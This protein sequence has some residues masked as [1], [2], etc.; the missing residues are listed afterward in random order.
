MDDLPILTPGKPARSAEMIAMHQR[1]A[2][3][4]AEL[5]L[6]A[7]RGDIKAFAYVVLPANG[8]PQT[9]VL[10]NLTD[11]M[12]L[13]GSMAWLTHAVNQSEYNARMASIAGGQPTAAPR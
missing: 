8:P 7:E 13:A 1:V 9:N 11:R 12:T 3:Q 2:K 10:D 4:F 6:A 5:A